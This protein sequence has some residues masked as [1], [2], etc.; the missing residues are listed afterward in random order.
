MKKVIRWWLIYYFLKYSLTQEI[1]NLKE[2]RNKLYVNIKNI[3]LYFAVICSILYENLYFL[4]QRN[5]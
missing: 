5:V 1:L 3:L 2:L 4:R